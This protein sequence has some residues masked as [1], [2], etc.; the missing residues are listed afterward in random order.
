MQQVCPVELPMAAVSPKKLLDRVFSL[1]VRLGVIAQG[2]DD[3]GPHLL[4]EG[5]PQL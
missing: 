1:T 4:K 5:L 3:C 2:Q